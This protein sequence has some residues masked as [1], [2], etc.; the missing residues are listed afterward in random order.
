MNKHI[1][2]ILIFLSILSL[3]AAVVDNVLF[4]LG[5]TRAAIHQGLTDNYQLAFENEDSSAVIHDRHIIVDLTMWAFDGFHLLG[6]FNATEAYWVELNVSSVTA[7]PKYPNYVV[8][9]VFE[10]ANHGKTFLSGTSFTQT[11]KLNYTDAYNITVCKH[12]FSSSVTVKGAVDVY[13]KEAANSTPT[14]TYS[15][16]TTPLPS[17][18]PSPSPTQTL[19]PSPSVPEFPSWIVVPLIL[20]SAFLIIYWRRGNRR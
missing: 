16:S 12:A 15:P 2:F 14:L 5:G 13:H 8:E 3:C 7:D 4:A 6:S 9:F 18:T 17:M 11:V 1:A 19:S 20:A 10:S